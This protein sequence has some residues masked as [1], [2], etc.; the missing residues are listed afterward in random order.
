M[1]MI[2]Y[3]HKIEEMRDFIFVDCQWLFDKLTELVEIKFTKSYNK[4]GYLCRGCR[5]I[6]NGRQTKH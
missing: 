1:G 5:S 4:K 2:F 3:Y 6:Y